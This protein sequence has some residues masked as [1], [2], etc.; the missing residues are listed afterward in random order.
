MF[1]GAIAALYVIFRYFPLIHLRICSLVQQ[2]VMNIDLRQRKI[3][4]F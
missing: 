4:L 3:N 2:Y 1:L